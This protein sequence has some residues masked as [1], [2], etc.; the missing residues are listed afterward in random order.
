MVLIR[1]IDYYNSGWWYGYDKSLTFYPKWKGGYMNVRLHEILS[2][3]KIDSLIFEKGVIH[4]TFQE[5]NK[6]TLKNIKKITFYNTSSL[7]HFNKKMVIPHN[8]GEINIY[9]RDKYPVN[10]FQFELDNIETK[11]NYYNYDDYM[12]D[13]NKKKHMNWFMF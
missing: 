2:K 4:H 8:V 1:L 11:I 12:A 5:I 7:E 10:A 9:Y 13:Y 3:G 6:A